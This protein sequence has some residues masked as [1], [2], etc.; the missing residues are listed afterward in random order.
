M[1]PGEIDDE[2]REKVQGEHN[3]RK[4]V[5]V[6]LDATQVII[7]SCQGFTYVRRVLVEPHR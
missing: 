7:E 4:G 5:N 2:F 6:D 1:R 3:K